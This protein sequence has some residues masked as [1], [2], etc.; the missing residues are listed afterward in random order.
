MNL[1]ATIR[2]NKYGISIIVTSVVMVVMLYRYGHPSSMGKNATVVSLRSL[3]SAAIDA[4]QRGGRIVY[5]IRLAAE[6]NEKSKG[7]TKEGANDPVTNGDLKSHLTMFYS[8]KKSFPEV[9]IISEEH[10]SGNLETSSVSRASTYNSEVNSVITDDIIVPIKDVRVWIDPLDATQEYTEN[11]REY[12]TTM[13]CV[14][15]KGYPTIGVIH[16][17]FVNFTA[18]GWSGKGVSPK[19]RISESQG[20]PKDNI[21]QIIVSRSHAGDVKAVAKA[22]FGDK[23]EVIPAG[24][25][26]YKTLAVIQGD[27]D[28]YIH[29]T[30]IKKWDI[31]AGNAILNAVKGNMTTLDG[32]PIDYSHREQYKNEGGVL[33]TLYEHKYYLP[34]LQNLREKKTP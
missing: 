2:I 23:T 20:G 17:P 26:G 24:G 18:W 10:D 32:L 31:C 34:K 21:P 16:K 7:K 19:L 4:A 13:V 28:A 33:A 14:A 3:L 30:I 29:V 25:A 15:V 22:A 27:V 8:L 6:L 5:D 1:G 11:L 9:E 12:V